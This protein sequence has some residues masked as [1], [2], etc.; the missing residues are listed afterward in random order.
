MKLQFLGAA[1]MVTGSSFLLEVA[2]KK[3]LIDCGLFQGSK[4]VRMLNYREFLYDPQTIDCVILTH[5]HIDHCGL[6]PKLC[7]NGF[8]GPIYATK[9]TNE[10]CRIMLPDSAHIQ[11]YDA[12]LINKKGQR[13]G[14]K[15]IEPIYTVDDAFLALQQFV[16]V[17]YDEDLMLDENITVRF[18]D[19]GHI[20][21]SAILEIFVHENNE[22]VKLLFSGDLGQPNQPIIKDPSIISGAD[23]VI[24]EST[25]GNRIHKF[26]DK[27]A[28]LAE[29]I[30]D[31]VARGGNI[32]IPSFAVG[33][34]QS[35]LYYL[36]KLVK[37]SKIPEIP[38]VIDSPLAIA[39]TNIIDNNQQEFDEET[40]AL[41]SYDGSI[42]DVP[43]LRLTKTFDESKELNNIEGSA[44][45]ISASGMADAGRVLH[46]LKHNLWRPE[47]SVLFVGYQAEDSMGKRLID[48]IKRVKIIGEEITVRAKIYNLD[49]FSAHADREQIVDWLKQVVNPIPNNIF[50]VHG[51]LSAS[52]P[53]AEYV[54]EVIPTKTYI[55][56]YGDIAII[57][58]RNW[59]IQETQVVLEP[60]VKDLEEIFSLAES[61][62]II[63]KK[64][65]LDLVLAQPNKLKETE[66]RIGKVLRYAKKILND[67]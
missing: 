45:I 35:V 41:L 4:A 26:Y 14:K 46:H 47:S 21:G 5:A 39:A 24:C 23:Y 40:L 38:I 36:S 48:G 11:E 50:L 20:M 22:T 12:S 64:R 31:T 56:K 9:V 29:I 58:G 7:K 27:E 17:D 2:D 59:H 34:T 42:L 19:A 13:S 44:I 18:N 66:I 15:I 54:E 62:F 61:D 30:N 52:Q 3:I 28:K 1:Q 63:I 53:F 67:L 51:E 10:L 49:G 16:E 33:R 37:E 57:D 8:K 55:P 25:Y 43:N 32:I 65:L 6:I 60:A